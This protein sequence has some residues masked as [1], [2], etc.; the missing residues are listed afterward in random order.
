MNGIKFVSFELKVEF[1][2]GEMDYQVVFESNN[3]SEVVVEESQISDRNEDEEKHENPGSFGFFTDDEQQEDPITD[4]EQVKTYNPPEKDS[5]EDVFK[6]YS[7]DKDTTK[8]EPSKPESIKRKKVFGQPGNIFRESWG[9]PEE[10]SEN[11]EEYFPKEKSSIGES[12]SEENVSLPNTYLPAIKKEN[13]EQEFIAEA[14]EKD[15]VKDERN[16]IE[17]DVFVCDRNEDRNYKDTTETNGNDTANI[18]AKNTIEEEVK[19]FSI[20]LCAGP[21]SSKMTRKSSGSSPPV[22]R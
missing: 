16:S 21:R 2:I 17:D 10:S 22:F 4:F 20:I 18:T 11:D 9:L 3:W 14:D 5:D 12:E 7:M 6:V 19:Q 15:Q 1:D 13:N 8:K